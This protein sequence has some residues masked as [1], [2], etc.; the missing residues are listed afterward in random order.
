VGR[1]KPNTLRTEVD[2]EY[3]RDQRLPEWHGWHAAR[4]GLGS[5]LYRLGVPDVVIQRLLRH[6][7]VSTTTGYYIKTAPADVH[8]AMTEFEN[9]VPQNPGLCANRARNITTSTT[10][11]L[12]N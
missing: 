10:P 2:H 11:R 3:Q 12:L 5:N 1:E 4:R 8:K 9:N 6:P 7:N